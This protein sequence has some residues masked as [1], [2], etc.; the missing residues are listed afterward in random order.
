MTRAP[1][2]P[3][4]TAEGREAFEKLYNMMPLFVYVQKVGIDDPY[5]RRCIKARKACKET[6]SGSTAR[7]KTTRAFDHYS[8]WLIH[9]DK[10]T[11]LNGTTVT[12]GWIVRLER[13]KVWMPYL[14][15]TK[16]VQNECNDF[17]VT[18]VNKDHTSEPNITYEDMITFASIADM[19]N[20]TKLAFH[21]TVLGI[22]KNTERDD[23][24]DE[25]IRKHEASAAKSEQ[26]TN[27]QEL[28]RSLKQLTM[29]ANGMFIK[30]YYFK[31]A[32][33][34]IISMINNIH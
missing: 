16:P 7:D 18:I 30:N 17:G 21:K 2:K 12:G 9:H 3:L 32:K 15:I 4:E 29:I 1:R 8:G 33:I 14:D 25:S 26:P 31:K 22:L 23:N 27:T 6:T 11:F 5:P 28:H 10:N 24:I 20:I 34:I 13:N 19:Y